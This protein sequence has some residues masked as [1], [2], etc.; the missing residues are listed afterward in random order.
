M[1]G[2]NK[3]LDEVSMDASDQKPVQTGLEAGSEETAPASKTGSASGADDMQP[4]AGNT[5][6]LD[7]VVAES[8]TKGENEPNTEQSKKKVIPSMAELT[9][10]A[11]DTVK[12]VGGYIKTF[13]RERGSSK[14]SAKEVEGDPEKG[15]DGLA[16]EGS[17]AQKGTLLSK[18][19]GMLSKTAESGK[20][21][22]GSAA[23]NISKTTE[24]TFT[25]VKDGAVMNEMVEKKYNNF[26]E[27]DS[28]VEI[29]LPAG[30]N[31]KI[32]FFVPKGKAVAWR[33][34]VKAL[35]IAFAVKLRVQGDGGST[36][37]EL[38][39]SRKIL[40]GSIV[41]GGRKASSEIERYILLE[42]DNTYSRLRPKTVLYQVLFGEAAEAAM[43]AA[44]EEQKEAEARA[45]E[46]ERLAAEEAAKAQAEGTG[47]GE[48]AKTATERLSD[49]KGGMINM[50]GSLSAAAASATAATM[51]AAS[52]ASNSIINKTKGRTSS[53]SG[54]V[55]G[56][57][58]AGQPA[59]D[60]TKTTDDSA[61]SDPDP[62]DDEPPAP[63]VGPTNKKKDD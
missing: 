29:Q 49:V 11:S 44:E 31:S 21:M 47:S 63:A 39:P 36:E 51:T 41:C 54:S 9:T 30:T 43:A 59:S 33:V 12:S 40:M 4:T 25:A 22:A 17:D 27:S 52:N 8:D 56:S 2:T 14:G 53:R 18:A 62:A 6:T 23:Q 1:E 45:E 5:E 3:E 60:A 61:K 35:D 55:D 24:F 26:K 38:E 19:S 42:I 15:T 32:P 7:E 10:S 20:Q 50:W 16:G 34:M 28:S 46:E 48:Q 58:L 37:Q 13:V 57:E